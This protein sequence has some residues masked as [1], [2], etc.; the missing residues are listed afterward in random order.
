GGERPTKFIGL[1]W[2]VPRVGDA[3]DL[4]ML[5][6]A[7]DVAKTPKGRPTL[8][9]VDS[10]IAYGVPG[11]QDH[12][13]AHGEP[14]GWEAI[15]GA[16]KFYGLDPEKTFDVKPSVYEHF[17]QGLGKR[18]AEL[19]AA[20]WKKIADYRAKC[21]QR[22]DYGERMQKRRL[23]E[24]WDKGLK[25]YPADP[26]GKAG[27]DVSGEVLN[28]LAQNVPWVIGGSAD[29]APSTKT[30]LTFDGAG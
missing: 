29:L 15:K 23:P 4:D 20:W 13:S 24:G 6:R 28:T 21:P 14:L 16:K 8:L 12:H 11:K 1:G 3:N 10:H 2:T 7:I 26:K 17:Q 19:T 25:V 27:R 18:G 5:Q 30:R 9:I 22:A